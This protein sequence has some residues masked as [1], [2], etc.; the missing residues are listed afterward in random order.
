[1]DT[2][3]DYDELEQLSTNEIKSRLA[4][5]GAELDF[6]KHPKQYYKEIYV[7]CI[8]N[9]EMKNMLVNWNMLHRKHNSDNYSHRKRERGKGRELTF[10]S[11]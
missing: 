1:M 6:Q 7:E 10:R 8:K 4:I 11:G 2:S 3:S 9:P 5:M